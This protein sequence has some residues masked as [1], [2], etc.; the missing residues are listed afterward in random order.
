MSLS[1][2]NLCTFVYQISIQ[3]KMSDLV[4]K[5]FEDVRIKESLNACIHCGTCT[6]IC[7][8]ASFY[9]Y[10]PRELTD[11]VQKKD[12]NILKNLL[13]SDY[14]WY[15]GECM[16]CKTRCPRENTPGVIIE[17]LRSLSQE[18]G[19]FV[20]SEKGRQQLMLKRSIGEWILDYG[21]C[22]VGN[23]LNLSLFPEQ[24]PNWQWVLDNIDL[25]F[26]KQGAHYMKEGSG[27]MRK[28][29]DEDLVEINK[30]F[31]IT[32]GNERFALIEKH[33]KDKAAEM[34]IQFDESHNCDYF[35]HIYTYNSNKK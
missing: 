6:A 14:I 33:S 12:E 34:G 29:P 17:A 26:E 15:C 27:A 3:R 35:K 5:L 2:K 23:N 32:G 30:I 20:E 10:D 1:E 28:V 9:D 18:T 25:V 24:G 11:M 13:S 21:Y 4:S 31:E 8:A 22:V 7:P 16:S 19:L